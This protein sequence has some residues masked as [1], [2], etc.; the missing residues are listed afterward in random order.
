MTAAPVSHGSRGLGATAWAPEMVTADPYNAQ[1]PSAALAE[2][3]TPVGAFFVRDHF[4]S[5]P[6]TPGRWQLR[7]GGAAAA[8]F[9]IGHDE[10]LAMEHR[11]LDV[12]VE[13]AG[14]GRSL[15]T[16]RPPGLPWSQQAVGC[17][18]FAGVPFRFL[19][20]RARIDPAAVEIVFTGA[21]SGTVR[22]HRTAFERSLPL[23]VALHPDTL[24]ATRMNGEPLAPE[25]GAPVRLVVP[26]RY[27]VADVKWLVG[28]R[29]VTQPFTGVFQAEEYRYVD[30]RG[31][32]DGPVTTV[33]VKSLITE[34]EQDDA[35]RRGH[36]T[37]VRGRAWSGDGVPVRRVE[38]RA[39]YEEDDRDGERGWHEAVLDPPAGPYGWTGWSYRWTPQQPGPYRLLSR[40]TDARGDRQPSQ[41]PWNAH[42]YGCNPVAC[43]E[44]VVV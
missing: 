9:G 12:V 33:R 19:A 11:E 17:A 16:P 23:A 15:M 10:L 38:V 7:I 18:H 24:L 27:A 42:G 6:A 4:G 35:V 1:T 31:T 36:E 39:A 3:L 40:A 30:S 44:V 13:C 37:L 29:A 20:D 28:A 32:P 34:P 22:G 8:P 14:N 43:V 25:H 41:A 5:P 21:D 26:G 2:P